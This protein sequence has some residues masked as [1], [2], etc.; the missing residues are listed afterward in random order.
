MRASQRGTASHRRVP[1]YGDD[2]QY[3]QQS[4]PPQSGWSPQGVSYQNPQAQANPHQAY[5]Y[6]LQS[7][8][9]AVH[10]PQPVTPSPPQS[11]KPPRSMGVYD[12]PPSPLQQQQQQVSR[13]MSPVPM[14]GRGGSSGSGRRSHR[15]NRSSFSQGGDEMAP[16]VG[17][18]AAAAA[19]AEPTR[20]AISSPP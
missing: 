19:A 17:S 18:A 9:G 3:Q 16:L 5:E 15:R 7:L 10:R 6:P 11:R 12:A 1:S 14:A 13:R 8:S 2:G 20:G 4:Q